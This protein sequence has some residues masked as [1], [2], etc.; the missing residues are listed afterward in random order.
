MNKELLRIILRQ[1]EELKRCMS[2]D[3][4][5]TGLSGLKRSRRALGEIFTVDMDNDFLFVL[6]FQ[7]HTKRH[8]TKGVIGM[9]RNLTFGGKCK[10]STKYVAREVTKEVYSMILYILPLF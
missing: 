8:T 6:R 1:K 2:Q 7:P 4:Q 3:C 9:M 10:M 5:R